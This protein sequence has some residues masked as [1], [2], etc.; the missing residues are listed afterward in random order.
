MVVVPASI[1]ETVPEPVSTTA[2]AVLLLLHVPPLVASLKVKRL[3][4]HNVPAPVID[5]GNGFTVTV[6]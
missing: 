6:L 2:I 3:P 5:K 1:P 4:V